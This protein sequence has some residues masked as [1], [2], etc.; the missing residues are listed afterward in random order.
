[1]SLEVNC[2]ELRKLALILSLRLNVLLT[3]YTA[4]GFRSRF[5]LSMIDNFDSDKDSLIILQLLFEERKAFA[6]HLP[7]SPSNESFVKTFY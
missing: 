1:M 6:I 4:A 3:K 5:I 2:A 7:F